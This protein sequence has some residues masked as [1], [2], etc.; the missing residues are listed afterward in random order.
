MRLKAVVMWITKEG[1]NWLS[2]RKKDFA[3]FGVG[4]QWV[5]WEQQ[6]RENPPQATEVHW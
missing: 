6:Q 1:Q 2:I 4:E 5:D 3:K